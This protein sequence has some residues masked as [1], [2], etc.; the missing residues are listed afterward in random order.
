MPP[1]VG[2]RAST[3][4]PNVL[5]KK[6][7]QVVLESFFQLATTPLKDDDTIS[8]VTQESGEGTASSL[9]HDDVEMATPPR[10]VPEEN[11]ANEKKPE[12]KE[13][14]EWSLMTLMKCLEEGQMM[15]L[16]DFVAQRTGLELTEDN[17]NSFEGEMAKVAQK[18]NSDRPPLMETPLRK[19]EAKRLNLLQKAVD[20]GGFD[21]KTSS[22]AAEFRKD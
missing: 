20:A 13:M 16:D 15:D 21:P 14:E 17:L 7:K 11:V 9:Q 5:G 2:K 18:L 6:T 1:N 8:S 22:L 3:E 12:K 4:E 19:R 10:N